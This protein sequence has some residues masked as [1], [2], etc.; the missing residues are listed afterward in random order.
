MKSWQYKNTDG[1]LSIAKTNPLL[2]KL[3][4]TR[5]IDT[6]EKVDKFLNPEKQKY[7]PFS[8]FR[9]SKMV[10]AR[11][12][13]AIDKNE[14]I[15][16]YGDFDT[17]GITSTAI[18]YKTLKEIGGNI[19]YY[20]PDRDE[21]NHGLN[22]KAIVNLISKKKAKLIITVDCGISNNTEINFAQTFKTDV[23]V[24]DHHEA[25]K[26]LPTAYA[27][28]NPKAEGALD[29]NITAEEIESL[30]NLSGAG[31]A[32]KLATAILE[33]Y[34][35]EDFFE[36]ILPIAAV[37]T[38][39]DIVPLRGENRKIVTC[40]LKAIR[41][42][43]NLGLTR[44][45]ENAGIKDLSKIN[46]ENIAFNAVPRLNAT[47]RLDRADTA[48]KLL[49]SN[50]EYEV[51]LITK[52]LN[53]LNAERQRLCAEAFERATI[54]VEEN[55]DEYKHS[56]IICDEEANIGIIGLSASKLVETY[57]KPAFVMKK[58]KNIYRCSCRGLQGVNIY[59]II[60]ENK[61]LFLNGGGHEFAGGFSFDGDK[62]SFEEVKQA[63]NETIKI[64]TNGKILKNILDID[65]KLTLQDIN[66]DII[67]TTKLLEPYGAE[68]PSPTF[69]IEN[70]K[71]ANICFMGNEKQHLKLLCI[72]DNGNFS[73][74]IKW[75]FTNFNGEKNDKIDIAFFPEKNEFNGK[76]NIQLLLKD[77]KL[78]NKI[79]KKEQNTKIIDCRTQQGG[80]DKIVDFANRTKKTIAIYS[81]NKEIVSY[82]Q[83]YQ[84]TKNKVFSRDNIPN[85]ID[86]VILTEIP[87]SINFFKKLI[88][89]KNQEILLMKYEN[90]EINNILSKIAGMLRYTKTKLNGKTTI[91]AMRAG[92]HFDDTI[93]EMG[94]KILIDCNLVKGE[95]SS[96]GEITVENVHCAKQEVIVQNNLYNNF[97]KS[98]IEYKNYVEKINNS[99]FE[100][101]KKYILE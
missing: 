5:N 28:I 62:V 15:I 89:N 94:I 48:F 74:C 79:S 32:L 8:I 90:A 12:K 53:E 24:T 68:N 54:Q 25:P 37:G 30:C 9:Q 46:S 71:I 60:E 84:A 69:A 80:Y 4:M 81:E 51:D 16:I 18:L 76:T 61:D 42:K 85:K 67:K 96:N 13:E 100:E 72:D 41:N 10:L 97:E 88:K 50:D 57:A 33:E 2:A 38:I 55:P 43:V 39:G 40:G 44:L 82:F 56:I 47:G 101:L 31:I 70:I 98:L 19:D 29:E 36:E 17:D 99:T 65:L 75:N 20:L 21:E 34:Q 59:K 64:Q 63:I 78:P 14:K 92:L 73:E 6:D 27:L 26:D 52:R 66:D 86:M 93:T 91:K 35:K 1:N 49:I 77:I 22:N 23:I 87:P 83:K 95:L 3:L 7:I 45:L 11:I 58:D